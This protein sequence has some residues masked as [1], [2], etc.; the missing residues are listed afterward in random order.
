MPWDSIRNK[1]VGAAEDWSR[2]AQAADTLHEAPLYIIDSGNVT[3]VDIRAKARRLA[4]RS[5]GLG[6]IIVDYLQLMSHTP[7]STA[8]S[9]RSP[10]SA[11]TSRCSRRTPDPGGRGLATEP[12]SR[13][14]SGQAAAAL[15]PP[16]VRRPRTGRRRRDVHPPGRLRP[17]QEGPRGPDRRQAPQRTHRHRAAHVPAAPPAVPQPRHRVVPRTGAASGRSSGGSS[18]TSATC[19]RRG[20]RTRSTS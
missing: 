7:G 15:G 10:R 16:R 2:I 8:A 4:A 13:A 17:G 12:R 3:L 1:R 14:A 5:A 9:R 6:L 18:A 20:P 19:S 11:A